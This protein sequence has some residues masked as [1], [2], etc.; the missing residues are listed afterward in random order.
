MREIHADEPSTSLVVIKNVDVPALF[1]EGKV[2]EM[3]AAIRG[4]CSDVLDVVPDVSTDKARKAIKSAAYKVT[5]SKTLLDDAGKAHVADLKKKTKAIDINRK[6]LRDGLDELRDEIRKPVDDYEKAEADR[7][8]KI[9]KAI[10][11]LISAGQFTGTSDQVATELERV[12]AVEI[13]EDVFAERKGDAAIQKDIAITNLER[14]LE[15]AKRDEDD[16]AELERLRREEE[17]RNRQEQDEQRQNAAR[18]Q[19]EAAERARAEKQEQAQ[20]NIDRI[21]AMADGIGDMTMSELQATRDTLTSEVINEDTYGDKVEK[22][23][24]A[25]QR[26][27]GHIQRE[28][29]TREA[30]E[31]RAREERKAREAREAEERAAD[32][33]H[34]CKVNQEAVRQL[35]EWSNLDEETANTVITLIAAGRIPGVKIE[36]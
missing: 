15:K 34:R 21:A 11:D 7:L 17:E 32:Q 23:E 33:E 5:R 13:T 26:T 19:A 16:A 27:L 30:A 6:T 25:K 8:E 22:A 29:N 10:S 3:I 9:E 36:Y 12:K 20:N 24:A 18:E 4:Q 1:E 31:R 35:C 28:I 14:A 2:D